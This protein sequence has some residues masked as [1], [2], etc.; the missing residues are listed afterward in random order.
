LAAFILVAALPG[1]A[2]ALTLG[3]TT[4]PAG[5]AGG[6]CI[7]GYAFVQSATDATYQY[8]VPADG[9]RITSWSTNTAGGVAETPL[10]LLLL[11]G[12][13][14]EFKVV[15]FDRETLPNPLPPS[16]VAT[17]QL[18]T[19]W[20]VTGGE[21]LGLYGPGVGVDCY[22][23]GAGVPAADVLSF[24]TTAAPPAIGVTYPTMSQGSILV[25][26]AAELSQSLDAG[27]TGSAAPAT[28][29]AGGA[30]EYAFTVSNSG[31]SAAPV[32]FTDGVPAGLTILS[33]V[34]GSGT[35]STAGQ[36]VSCTMPNLEAGQSAPVSILVAAPNAGSYSDTAT[37]SAVSGSLADTNPGNNTAAATLNV[38]APALAPVTPA[39]PAQCKVV[40]LAGAPL[41]VAKLVIEA[42]NCKVGKV[43][44]KASKSV[45]KGYV[46]STT[47]R[48]GATLAAG[49]A[50]G[51]VTSSGP[52]KKHKK[53]KH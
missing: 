43:T 36:T 28:I 27:I 22:Y 47:P 29:T 17:F 41:S 34:A 42:L 12:G 46:L 37:V 9:G 8:K 16:G 40:Q 11:R 48:S 23:S 31:V 35:C 14:N 32:T 2:S 45:R 7:T 39:P 33:A 26:V 5:A 15:N 18:P 6:A 1:A 10:T 3:T 30:S 44:S 24:D 13:G 4:F 50:V 20:T 19:P 52:P 21:L 53:K 25:N 38:N 51:V 49:S